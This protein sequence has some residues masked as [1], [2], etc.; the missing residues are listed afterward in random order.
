M[1]WQT[2]ASGLLAIQTRDILGQAFDTIDV[3]TRRTSAL[4]TV[5]TLLTF[6][7]GDALIVR[8]GVQEITWFA[9]EPSWASA[10]ERSP[11]SRGSRR[12]PQL[13]TMTSGSARTTIIGTA[14]TD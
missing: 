11:G 8:D 14:F 2:T 12:G 9:R 5:D 1:K 3:V 7:S 13:Q 4:E 6:P 10:P